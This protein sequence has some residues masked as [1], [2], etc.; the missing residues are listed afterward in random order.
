MDKNKGPINKLG[1]MYIGT[2]H[3][4]AKRV[5]EAHPKY[6]NYEMLDENKEMAFLMS[7]G[8]ALGFGGPGY[9]RRCYTFSPEFSILGLSSSS[10][11][12]MPAELDMVILT[13]TGFSPRSP[14]SMLTFSME[15]TF[16]VLKRVFRA[17]HV[18]VTTVPRVRVKMLFS[19]FC[20]NLMQMLTLRK[21]AQA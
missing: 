11:W 21:Q 13:V 17:G 20:Y 19:C 5:L 14:F 2:I 4:Y 3:G 16:A 9:V 1:E 7:H 6:G 18:L 10:I 8:W 12:K 15:R